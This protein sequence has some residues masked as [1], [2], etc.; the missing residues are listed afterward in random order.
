MELPSIGAWSAR[1]DHFCV[2]RVFSDVKRGAV[3]DFDPG[4]VINPVGTKEED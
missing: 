1:F 2:S 3:K 4:D